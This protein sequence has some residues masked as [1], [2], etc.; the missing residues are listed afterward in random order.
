[1]RKTYMMLLALVLS[2]MGVTSAMAQ[3]VYR[4]E[5]DKSMF[6]AWDGYGA[7]ANEVAN[8]AA[9]DDGAA[10]FGCEFNLYRELGPGNV[11]YGNTNVY[12]LWYAD[13]TGTQKMVIEGT[14]GMQLR[15]LLNR[16][17]PDGGD[18]HG[19]QTTELNVTLDDKGKG[20][21]DLSSL[22]FVHLNCIK[23]GWGSP[24]GVINVLEIIGSI[25]PV[26]GFMDLIN[27]GDAEGDDLESFPV[28]KNGPNNG[29]TANDRPEI[30]AGGVDGS[31]CLK[32]VSDENP[33]MT[34]N[35]QFYLKFDEALQEGDKWKL[36]MYV[37]AERDAWI[38]T[39]AQAAPRTWNGGFI[40]P[41]E[42]STEWQKFE[43]SGTVSAQQANNGGFLSAAFDLN[44]GD[45]DGDNFSLSDAPNTFYFDNIVFQKDMGGA[46]PMSLVTATVGGDVIRLDLAGTTNMKKLVAAAGGKTLFFPNEC[47]TVV[48]NGKE[49]PLVSVE[50]RPD[51]NL[52]LFMLEDEAYEEDMVVVAFKNPADAEHHLVFESGKWQG[53]DVPEMSGLVC[54]YN[55]DLG[56]GEYSSSLWG[57]PEVESAIPENGSFNLDPNLKEFKIVFNQ[58]VKV[59]SIKAT[60]GNAALTA[61]AAGD[62]A[63]EVTLTYNGGA[64]NGATKLIISAIEG[65]K[66][67]EE[68]DEPIVLNYSFG[69][70]VIDENDQPEVIY[71]SNFTND[72]DDAQAAG[73]IVT[74]D[75][76]AGMQPA[77]SGAGNRLQHG[78]TGYAAD[79]L[80]LAQRSA[81]AGIALYG[82]EEDHKLTLAGGKT[83]HLTLKSAQW[84]AY[85]ASGSNRTL[86]AQILTED[87]VNAEDG[88]IVDEFG[89]LGEQFQVVEGRV[90]EDKE[91]TAFDIAFTPQNDGN[92]VI[93]LVAGNLD[94]NPAG[95]GDGN[96]IA[97]VKVEYI[98]NVMGI[99]EIKALE[100]ALETAKTS[101]T[102]NS[103]E[104][105]AGAAYNTLDQ[106]IKQ[107][108]GKAYEMTT[109]SAFNKATEDLAAGTKAL[110]D[111]AKLCQEY[112]ALPQQA[113]DLYEQYKDSKYN[114]T[115]VFE[116]LKAAVMKYCELSIEEIINEETGESTTA[117]VM[118]S[119][120]L[121]YDDAELTAAKDELS[122]VI[123]MTKKMFSEGKSHN[124][125]GGGDRTAGYA[126]L[127]ERLRRGVDL[128]HSLGVGDDAPEIVA[129]NAEL[130]DNDEIAAAI[131]QRATN[132]I[133]AD[134]ASDDSQLFAI[135]EEGES[136]PTYDLG[137]FMKN[138]NIY[139][140]ANSTDL[141]GW[142][143][144][145]GNCTVFP[146]WGAEH[147]VNTPY[148]EDCQIH[149]GW[150]PSGLP[151]VEQTIEYLPAGIYTIHIDGS[152]NNSE[153]SAGTYGYVKTSDTPALGEEE[154]LDPDV[155]FAGYVAC[156]GDIE[157]IEVT[158][159]KLTVGFSYGAESQA[160][161]NDV[162]IKLIAPADGF[163][164]AKAYATDITKA[165]TQAK[166]RTIQLFD[167][168]GQRISNGRKGVYI[169]K[170]QMS[171]GTVRTEKVI[172][173]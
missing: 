32:V 92:F 111:H 134:L 23:T 81:A 151:M 85:P 50:G 145:R 26:S 69:P 105:Y 91:F 13:L 72:G 138:P 147:T 88:T 60:L 59:A 109:P 171:D 103:D 90:K 132:L 128:L 161:I 89:I 123:D 37:K 3:R 164:Y 117:E 35:T 98:P 64:L 16:P 67:T 108:D 14:A 125:Y 124:W 120:K 58:N 143:S 5:L 65:E 39:S 33:E 52:Y 136:A 12:Y 62:I 47:A 127:H 36:S 141:P 68:L 80:Y 1:M 41:F 44:N 42:V 126:A 155:H 114:V 96:A 7:N 6:K 115:D 31:R 86:R 116:Q 34:W 19:G 107:Y 87:A 49:I 79:V 144:V 106:L 142:T 156:S 18:A 113:V 54:S 22:E 55:F 146:G 160:F 140:P 159:G 119:F 2:V 162:E 56:S 17:E 45:R 25:R 82:T 66:S 129:A 93:R 9:I 104:R 73:W 102:E 150:H 95:F 167:L 53:E 157:G 168:N 28:S 84:D 135:P 100:A 110:N 24:A 10:T 173:K 163:D 71:L 30:V 97:D 139:S 4:A 121:Y 170:K 149:A 38:T 154:E 74:A 83:Y 51:G 76:E 122:N 27:N 75:N 99:V 112:D 165:E 78:Q 169:V 152:D 166:V 133:L 118:T 29:G 11:V 21:V 148:A 8:P 172:K 101:L 158:D 46:N 61:S 63:K 130:G 57:A 94:G 153:V 77:N 131:M 70:T 20:E 40:D 15:I 137:V 43:F 48:L